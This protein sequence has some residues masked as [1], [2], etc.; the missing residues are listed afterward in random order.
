M[1]MASRRDMWLTSYV[2]GGLL[3]SPG[4][5]A[6]EAERV[7]LSLEQ[8]PWAPAEERGQRGSAHSSR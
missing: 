2:I 1:R 7:F 4:Y 8:R 5:E 3:G 6:M